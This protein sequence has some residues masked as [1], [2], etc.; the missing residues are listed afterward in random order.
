MSYSEWLNCPDF[1]DYIYTLTK[2]T[3]E[4]IDPNFRYCVVDDNVDECYLTDDIGVA[5]EFAASKSKEGHHMWHICRIFEAKD[6]SYKTTIE[7]FCAN[8]HYIEREDKSDYLHIDFIFQRC[9]GSIKK[10]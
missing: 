6:G 1:K 3:R 5:M 4:S 10:L 8:G 2:D 7:G 9:K